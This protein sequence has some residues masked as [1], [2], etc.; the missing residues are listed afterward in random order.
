M[1][2]S[3]NIKRTS[4]SRKDK[5]L[6]LDNTIK[7]ETSKIN[8]K[9]AYKINSKLRMKIKIY[10]ITKNKIISNNKANKK[11]INSPTGQWLRL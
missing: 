5:R 11:K 7:E 9:K 4:Y 3:Y 6:K 10:K 2:R 8:S 1:R